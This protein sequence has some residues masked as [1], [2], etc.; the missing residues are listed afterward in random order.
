MTGG[1]RSAYGEMRNAY[2][3][4]IVK[5]KRKRTLRI[6]GIDERIIFIQL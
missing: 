3:S 4:S 6:A 1:V 2:R 5:V